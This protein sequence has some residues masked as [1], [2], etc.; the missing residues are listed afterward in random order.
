MK[1]V[2]GTGSLGHPRNLDG[3][4]WHPK[5]RVVDLESAKI[6]FVDTGNQEGPVLLL[7]HGYVMSSWAWR[8]NI[9]AFGTSHRIIAIC[10]KGFGFSEKPKS[11][12]S[13]ESLAGVVRELLDY[14][15]VES[16]DVVGHSMGGAIALRLV[17]DTPYLFRRFVLVCS[18]GLPWQLPKALT[19]LPFPML[20]SLSNVLFRRRIMK[21]VLTWLGYEKPIVN[22]IYMDTYMRALNS[23]GATFAAMRTAEDFSGGLERLQDVLPEIEHKTL[24]LWGAKDKL[25]PLRAGKTFL[26]I[27]QNARLEVFQDCGHCPNEEDSQRFNR[28]VLDFL[29]ESS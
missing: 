22:E 5:S 25:V 3:V 29:E 26:N 13:L 4:G 6:H 12:Y 10:H 21:R 11:D 23:R 14:L 15:E 28:V 20:V 2:F 7:L 19:R 1:T 9:E 8:L 17:G 27:L 24:L 18:A 16:C